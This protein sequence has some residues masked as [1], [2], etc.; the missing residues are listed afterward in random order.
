MKRLLKLSTIPNNVVSF[1]HRYL[2][3]R[4]FFTTYRVAAEA[5][6]EEER[7]IQKEK[8]Q[9]S[10]WVKILREKL[11]KQRNILD[12][13]P[14]NFEL[15]NYERMHEYIQQFEKKQKKEEEE[16]EYRYE[17]PM[18]P[19]KGSSMAKMVAEYDL[20][21]QEA[22]LNFLTFK[23]PTP[24]IEKVTLEKLMSM[25]PT[26]ANF[27]LID[28]RGRLSA[29]HYVIPGSVNIPLTEIVNA[30]ELPN[31]DFQTRYGIPKPSP[32]TN[33]IFF[34]EDMIETE[35]ACQLLSA[36]VTQYQ[37]VYNYR[38]GVQEWFG[39]TYKQLWRR[40]FISEYKL[41]IRHDK[42]GKI[43]NSMLRSLNE[44]TGEGNE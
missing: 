29:R 36:F 20:E 28:V 23:D 4:S 44:L 15:K 35:F 25:N 19:R 2:M 21:T 40:S 7:S 1:K 38:G 37:L 9:D 8:G 3:T 30:F 10:Q 32:G 41:L 26:I 33:I 5:S 12:E 34:S 22:L 27:V 18:K 42:F 31:K 24:I 17:D 11:D 43:K 13:E 14:I 6:T 16:E 39:A